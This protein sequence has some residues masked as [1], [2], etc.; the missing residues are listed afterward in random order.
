LTDGEKA[1][2]S[3]DGPERRATFQ[4]RNTQTKQHKTMN[5]EFITNGGGAG[6]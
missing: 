6:W 4:T 3:G 5:I 2:E 1:L